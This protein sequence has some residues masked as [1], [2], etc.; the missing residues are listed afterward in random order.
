LSNRVPF[1]L[2]DPGGTFRALPASTALT[3]AATASF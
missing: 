1:V 2:A 3:A